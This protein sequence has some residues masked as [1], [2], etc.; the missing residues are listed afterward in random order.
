[1]DSAM[2]NDDQSDYHVIHATIRF[3]IPVNMRKEA[4]AILK[5]VIEPTRHEEGCL[6]CRLYRDVQEKGAIMLEEI[7]SN[8]ALLLEHLAADE[9]R[10]VLLVMEMAATPPEIRFSGVARTAGMETIEQVR[11]GTTA[12]DALLFRSVGV[13]LNIGPPINGEEKR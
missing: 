9:F 13:D 11:L 10:S 1:M 5:S 3:L 12:A 2:S 7:W 6:H 8:E 4:M